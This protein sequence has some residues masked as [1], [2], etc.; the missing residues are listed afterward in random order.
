LGVVFVWSMYMPFTGPAYIRELQ[1]SPMEALASR[2]ASMNETLHL[3]PWMSS[4]MVAEAK[5]CGIDGAVM[6][7]PPDNRLSQSGNKL[8]ALALKEAGV[9]V[10]MID[11][12]M[13]DANSWDH[14]KM[15]SLV[16]DFAENH[17]VER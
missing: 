4:W 14:D 9:P 15:V 10:L 3:P 11:G 17:L 8:T 7:L 16:A 12:D 6:L 13:V 5:R 2:V 1:G